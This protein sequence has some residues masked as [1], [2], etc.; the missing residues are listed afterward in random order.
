MLIMTGPTQSQSED[1]SGL[2]LAL[3]KAQ[4]EYKKLSTNRTADRGKAGRYKYATLDQ[5]L[6]AI[7]PA[8]SKNEIAHSAT[9]NDGV[10]TVSLHWHDQWKS[11]SMPLHFSGGWQ[12][13]GSSRTYCWR[14]L[15]APL[16]GISAD[17][18]DDGN[19]GDGKQAV[20]T[21]PMDELCDILLCHGVHEGAEMRTWIETA[22]KRSVPD[23]DAITNAEI[24]TMIEFATSSAAWSTPK[25]APA[26]AKPAPATATPASRLNKALEKLHP[27][28]E[29][30]DGMKDA[31]AA[32]ELKKIAK[33]QW[34]NGML[35][36]PT[37]IKAF[38]ELSES[39]V[40]TLITAAE[41]GEMPTNPNDDI[42]SDD[43]DDTFP[44]DME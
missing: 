44:T 32:A 15:L 19:V 7:T 16:S 38:A 21:D 35:R 8:L 9:Y 27:W 30:L 33:L 34:A 31:K 40:A 5:V 24:K 2:M 36:L 39:Q 22:L 3:A 11:S 18:D 29:E 4:G 23:A 41:N 25:S 26:A 10:L 42:P 12:E 14:Y 1:I 37:A 43:D 13:F 6:E 28:T 17:Y 20:I